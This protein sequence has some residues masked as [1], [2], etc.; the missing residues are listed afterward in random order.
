MKRTDGTKVTFLITIQNNFNVLIDD[1]PV[2]YPIDYKETAHIVDDV[3]PSSP[4]LLG[5]F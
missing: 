1:I 4:K 2:I 5:C 3:R